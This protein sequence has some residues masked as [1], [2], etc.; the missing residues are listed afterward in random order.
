MTTDQYLFGDLRSMRVDW[1]S[2]RLNDFVVY[3]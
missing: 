2:K 1:P 3:V